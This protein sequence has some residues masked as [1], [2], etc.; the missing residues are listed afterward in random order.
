MEADLPTARR[1]NRTWLYAPYILLAVL[2]VA[3]SAGWIYIRGR[4][5]GGLD[6][7]VAAEASAN[8]QWACPGREVGG[9]PFRIEI[10]CASLGLTRPDGTA[11][12]GRLIVV[13]Q[14]YAPNHIIAEV[15]GPLRVNANGT[16][17]GAEWTLLQASTH[18]VDGRP[19]RGDLVAENPVV[20]V[21]MSDA[22]PLTLKGDR[23]EL[24]ARPQPQDPSA[25]D[26]ALSAKR[27]VVPGLDALVGGIEPADLDAI[28]GLNH[29]RD[30]PARPI[31]TEFERWRAADGRLDVARIT[32]VKGPTR[33]EG[34]GEASIDELHRPQGQFDLASKGVGGFLGRF[35]GGRGGGAAALLGA[36][37]GAPRAPAGGEGS[38]LTPL[39]TIRFANGKLYLG[40]LATG[41]KLP[42]LY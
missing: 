18:I 41:V 16:S 39:P 25:L 28:F 8:R 4:V 32:L 10:T 40:P 2:A 5:V 22:D 35:V 42:V 15:S 14:V 17:V 30:L 37:F 31:A 34:R 21:E 3:W 13:A 33:L 7:W 36:L 29:V 26:L 11:S 20:R 9:Y 6:E 1:P 12:L 24:H 27:T 19:Q 23:L 38:D